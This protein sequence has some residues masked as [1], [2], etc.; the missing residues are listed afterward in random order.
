MK[1]LTLFLFG[2]ISTLCG[3]AQIIPFDVEIPN[4]K[5][6]KSKNGVNIRQRPSVNSKKLIGNYEDPELYS[7]NEKWSLSIPKGYIA[8]QFKFG[9]AIQEQEG[10]YLIENRSPFETSWN[11]DGWVS[12]K[13]CKTFTPEPIEY[14]T[15][16]YKNS[17]CNLPGLKWITG[18]KDY[19]EG[20]YVLIL[21]GCY[22]MGSLCLLNICLGKLKDG[23]IVCPFEFPIELDWDSDFVENGDN[24]FHIKAKS[25]KNSSDSYWYVIPPKFKEQNFSWADYTI[26][27][28][29]VNDLLT[30]VEPEKLKTPRIYYLYNGCLY[31]SDSPEL[32]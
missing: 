24:N 3:E 2:I 18:D 8:F 20:E 28:S 29:F 12:A 22:E 30:K 31:S 6:I 13:Y 11:W 1:K 23:F 17:E 16:N 7:E 21:E 32:F 19:K 14:L 25:V 15:K 9:V 26:S 10:W 27:D 5:F 4:V